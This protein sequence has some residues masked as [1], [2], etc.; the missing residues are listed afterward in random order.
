MIQMT[1]IQTRVR[2]SKNK[3]ILNEH[4]LYVK[5]TELRL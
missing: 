2:A 3:L 4:S 1:L 5:H